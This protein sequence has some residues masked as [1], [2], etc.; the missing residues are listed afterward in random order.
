MLIPQPPCDLLGRPVLLE[1]TRYD[2]LQ[3]W[4]PGEQTGLGSACCIPSHLVGLSGPIAFST[5][6]PSDFLADRGD[7]PLKASGDG[8]K[9][10]T[11]R[12]AARD[13]LALTKAQCPGGANPTSWCEAAKGLKY[14]VEVAGSLAQCTADP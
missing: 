13:L 2:P 1:F 14:T 4:A 5:S 11:R 6:V 12:D 8:S 10:L 7:S 3:S 9:C